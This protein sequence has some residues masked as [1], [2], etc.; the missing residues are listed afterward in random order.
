MRIIESE[1]DELERRAFTVILRFL[2]D[3]AALP[4]DTFS[5]I[6]FER[7]KVVMLAAGQTYEDQ[8]KARVN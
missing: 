3:E 1:F 4:P 7:R 8:K 2:R 5:G 6:P